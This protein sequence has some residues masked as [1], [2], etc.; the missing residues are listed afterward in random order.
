MLRLHNVVSGY[1][2]KLVLKNI[3]LTIEQGEIVTLIGNNGA[4][5]S[6]TLKTIT[7]FLPVLEGSIEFEDQ[8][9]NALTTPDIVDLGVSMVPEGRD[10][11]STLSV[12]DNLRIG[13]FRR[14]EKKES[15][16]KDMEEM[17]SLFPVLRERGSQL[18]G[19]LSGGEAQML[20]IARGLM[21]KPRLLLLDEPSMG[22]APL[23]VQEVF[24]IIKRISQIGTTILLVE[25]NAT[26]ALATAGR[27]YIM[28]NGEIVL[29]DSAGN[30]LGNTK[31]RD[32]YLGVV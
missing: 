8:K 24:E 16:L 7:R 19:T 20:A 31:V 17:Y 14:R 26:M 25:Q 30:L 2:K 13:A 32:A 23:I 18:G 27:G 6:T 21:S 3:S 28:E 11:F 12:D 10:I 29:Q 5:K 4:G 15:L 22:L 9:I 1:G